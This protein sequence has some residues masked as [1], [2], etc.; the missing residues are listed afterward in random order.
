MNT[1]VGTLSPEALRRLA[2]AL[3]FK[4]QIAETS[5][6]A[7]FP[8]PETISLPLRGHGFGFTAS[9]ETW[10]N[11]AQTEISFELIDAVGG[12]L[13]GT[14]VWPGA[15][16]LSDQV[17]DD[18]VESAETTLVEGCPKVALSA[19]LAPAKALGGVSPIDASPDA[20]HKT[21]GELSAEFAQFAG[22]KVCAT[23]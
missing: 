15:A 16:T 1:Q 11:S 2:M 20:L 3:A 21:A 14:F 12:T 10:R 18:L 6:Y 5:R 8:L 23:K 4:D 9:G 17:A 13:S 7:E 19:L 22:V